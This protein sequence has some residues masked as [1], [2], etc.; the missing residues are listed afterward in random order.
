[1]TAKYGEVEKGN[2]NGFVY[3]GNEPIRIFWQKN[4]LSP[5]DGQTVTITGNPGI[6]GEA[7]SIQGKR[8][9]LCLVDATWQ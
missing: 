4:I 6:A 2:P 3:F 9:R 8:I 5:N 7:I 1:M